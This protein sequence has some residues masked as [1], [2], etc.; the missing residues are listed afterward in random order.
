MNSTF[1]NFGIIRNKISIVRFLPPPPFSNILIW[2]SYSIRGN[3]FDFIVSFHKKIG[4][5]G[6]LRCIRE[7]NVNQSITGLIGLAVLLNI[8]KWT[9]KQKLIFVF[10][11]E[12]K[13][14]LNHPNNWVAKHNPLNFHIFLTL[15]FISIDLFKSGNKNFM[16]R[17]YLE[18]LATILNNI[19]I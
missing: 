2:T 17:K 8:N 7:I 11:L 19:F 6:Q 15:I 9:D 18:N 3:I 4:L 12:N 1:F 14:Y 5:I 16:R 13:Y 10:Y